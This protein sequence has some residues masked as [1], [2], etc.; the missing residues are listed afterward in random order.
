M[1]G[2]N[3]SEH[4]DHDHGLT[5]DIMKAMS[6]DMRPISDGRAYRA[7]SAQRRMIGGLLY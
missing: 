3:C 5:T 2:I 7:W 4:H 1:H 6:P